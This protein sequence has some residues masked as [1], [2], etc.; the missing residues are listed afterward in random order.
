[1]F[2]ESRRAQRHALSRWAKIRTKSGALPRD[3]LLIDISDSGIRLHADAFEVP[4]DFVLLLG[5][6]GAGAA[7]EC[8]VVWRLGFEIGASFTDT[9]QGFARRFLSSTG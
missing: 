3:C 4:D 7:R 9:R 6:Q 8:R 2:T 1:M 5:D